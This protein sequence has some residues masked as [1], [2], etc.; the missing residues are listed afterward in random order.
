VAGQRVVDAAEVGPLV[1]LMPAGVL[2]LLV[3]TVLRRRR[4]R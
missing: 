1:M 4:H 3:A 2:L